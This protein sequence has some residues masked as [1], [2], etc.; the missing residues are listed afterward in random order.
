MSITLTGTNATATVDRDHVE[1]SL[2]E[3]RAGF[4][5]GESA[6]YLGE[7]ECPTFFDLTQRGLSGEMEAF[8]HSTLEGLPPSPSWQDGYYVDEVVEAINRSAA[9]KTT[10]TLPLGTRP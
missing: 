8:A 10:V 9:A 1:L 2:R 3:E 5:K 6:L 7:I 4:P